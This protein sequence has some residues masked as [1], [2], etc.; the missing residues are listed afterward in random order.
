MRAIRTVTLLGAALLWGCDGG[1]TIEDAKKNLEAACEAVC[2]RAY[3]PPCQGLTVD[4]CKAA[5]PYLEQQLGEACLSE[6]AA[7]YACTA[8]SE[9]Q[10]TENGPQP[11]SA[12]DCADEA[13]T[14]V[15]CQEAAPCKTYCAK[16]GECDGT[17]VAS[18]E[19]ECSAA[20]NGEAP[21]YYYYEDILECQSE[22]GDLVCEQ[23]KLRPVGCDGDVADYASC[24]VSDQDL[25]K[26]FCYLSDFVG[27]GSETR[28][29]CE[30]TCGA[31]QADAETKGCSG[32]LQTYRGCQ[33]GH[34][35]ACKDGEPSIVGCS[36]ELYL[37]QSCME[38]N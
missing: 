7:M 35:L 14:A 33:M 28:A 26:G 38:G 9:F 29:G 10:C 32:Q 12:A 3:D 22:E 8:K 2:E 13:L 24:L 4:Q 17:D 21:C 27:C 37:Y 19:S 20:I 6:Y 25:C 31:E 30:A 36:E 1:S 34:G 11:I 23:G 5:C 15:Q 16:K 18:C